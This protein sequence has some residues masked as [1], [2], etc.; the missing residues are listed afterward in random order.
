MYFHATLPKSEKKIHNRTMHIQS[1]IQQKKWMDEKN[2]IP[3]NKMTKP[4]KLFKLS[5]YNIIIC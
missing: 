3:T 2:K 1:N 4:G 5:Y